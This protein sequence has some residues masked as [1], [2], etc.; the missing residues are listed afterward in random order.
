[1]TN[2]TDLLDA[3]G[4]ALLTSWPNGHK[5][6]LLLAVSGGGDSIALLHLASRWA[7]KNNFECSV[8][9]IDHGLREESASEAH[10]VSSV[11]DTLGLQHQTVN[12]TGWDGFGNTQMRARDARYRLIE[13][14]RGERSVV[15]TAHTLEDQAETFLMRLKRGSGVYGLASILPRQYFAFQQSGYWLLRPFLNIP[16][17]DLR[18][19]LHAEGHNWVEDPTNDDER[20]DRIEIR[21]SM[22]GLT[23]LGITH[24][25]LAS[26]ASRLARVRSYM[27]EQVIHIAGLA[28][29]IDN[30][31]ILIDLQNFLSSHKEIQY[32]VFS[33][34]LNWVASKRYN[35]RFSSLERILE[36]VISGRAQTLHGCFIHSKKTQI[37][38]TRE[39]NAVCDL[40]VSFTMD[41]TWD[42][43]WRFIVKPGVTPKKDWVVKASGVEGVKWI[44]SNAKVNFPFQSLKAHPGIFDRNGV[45]CI[46]N[47]V[48][49]SMVDATFCTKLPMESG[50]NY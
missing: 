46:P 36:N 4:A 7:V 47:I 13:Q 42:N 25:V 16:R 24:E 19:F 27:E 30:G 50:N 43:R 15:L 28:L 33:K 8:I 39:Y 2:D 45:V 21:K 20:Y 1:M 5:R 18:S 3:L 34:A 23:D 44:K 17:Q 48:A 31:D 41:C 26:T 49:N 40:G 14:H 38:I 6:H 22:R 12:W 10:F 9:T 37:R 32:R 29:K 35:P 11:A